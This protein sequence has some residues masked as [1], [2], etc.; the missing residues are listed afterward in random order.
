MPDLSPAFYI[1][2]DFDC[3]C[4][5]YLAIR[6]FPKPELLTYLKRSELNN[7]GHFPLDRATSLEDF[8]FTITPQDPDI[9][10]FNLLKPSIA[11]YPSGN[12]RYW[13]DTGHF[14]LKLGDFK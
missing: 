1:V 9:Y 14:T 10:H 11:Q 4:I 13:Q 6:R 7:Y 5:R 8:G 12:C 3:P 2:N